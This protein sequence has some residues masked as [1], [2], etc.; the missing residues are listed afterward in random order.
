MEI[1]LK[2]IIRLGVIFLLAAGPVPWLAISSGGVAY[3]DGPGEEDTP[4]INADSTKDEVQSE[5]RR[6]IEKRFGSGKAAGKQAAGKPRQTPDVSAAN[7][8]NTPGEK[9]GGK[10]VSVA[11]ERGITLNFERTE[12]REVVKTVLGDI[13]GLNYVI[14]PKVTGQVTLQ[15]SQPFQKDALLSVLQSV[16]R[17][18]GAALIKVDGLYR[19]VPG[20]AAA[21]SVLAPSFGTP[22]GPGYQT[23]VVPLKYM[24]ASQMKG[25]L[26]PIVPKGMVF[27][28]NSSSN[29]L[30]LSG[31]REE[32]T[33]ILE[34][35]SIFDVDALSKKSVALIPLDYTSA[36]TLAAELENI[37]GEELGDPLPEVLRLIP[38]VR[39]NAI[40]VI[41]QQPKYLRYV[42]D[43]VTRLDETVDSSEQRVYVYEVQNSSAEHLAVVLGDLFGTSGSVQDAGGQQ[44]VAPGYEPITLESKTAFRD[45]AANQ[46][47]ISRPSTSAE[48]PG[49]Q[50]GNLDVN[51]GGVHILADTERNSLVIRATPADY[52]RI[53]AALDALDT[54]PLQVHIE[55]SIVE[56]S[57][58]G[59]LKYGIQ[60]FFKNSSGGY[61]G[62][63]LL[64]LDGDPL[65]SAVI[66]GF[67]YSV[68]GPDDVVRAVLNALAGDSRLKVI[69]SPSLMV[70]DN[71]T[72]QIRIGDQQPVLTGSSQSDGGVI[73]ESIEYK[74]TGVMLEVTPRVNAGGLVIMDVVQ[75]VTDVGEIDE[76]TGQRSFLQR[77]VNS[78]VAV[79][80]GETVVMG[81]L[82]R[83][84]KSTSKAGIPILRNLPIL[85]NLFS[86]TSKVEDRTELMVLITPTSIRGVEQ[87]RELT[88]EFRKKL[89]SLYMLDI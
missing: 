86:A 72:A 21:G 49:G 16:L 22:S 76:A 82:I 19:V 28:V 1:K 7:T 62:E 79:Q 30:L 65:L 40:L 66:P 20:A 59:Q 35:I 64:D 58:S 71:H 53:R 8:R 12:I 73:T 84:N 36:V 47:A 50:A 81:G 83:D 17:M 68:I 23:L 55:A 14:D 78:V 6:L 24:P 48:G 74:D 18:N 89:D 26:E 5:L 54:I 11:K 85:G 56:V 51:V 67:S 37:L 32:L 57:L 60:W 31:S 3:A 29:L 43:W 25:I 46:Q 70:L 38:I 10:E 9:P 15:T 80:S 27:Q 4:A 63:G 61:G 44:Q 52:R 33:G 75:E 41:T 69:S 88:E 39:M 77:N 2:E 42:R 13:L 45:V 34:T 87:A